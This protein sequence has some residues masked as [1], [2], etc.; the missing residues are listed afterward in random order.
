MTTPA[1]LPPALA[2]AFV[3][4][5]ERFQPFEHADRRRL[6]RALRIVLADAEAEAKRRQRK[7]TGRN[8]K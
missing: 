2:K 6:L 5:L 4:L 1:P 8:R 7:H 3:E